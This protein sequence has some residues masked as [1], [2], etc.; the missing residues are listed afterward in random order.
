MLKK[1]TEEPQWPRPKNF[2]GTSGDLAQDGFDVESERRSKSR[3][4]GAWWTCNVICR[5]HGTADIDLRVAD[6]AGII[7]MHAQR[8]W[9]GLRSVTTMQLP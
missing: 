5:G 8:E 6:C 2:C 4:P 1:Y 3:G 9:T 7:P